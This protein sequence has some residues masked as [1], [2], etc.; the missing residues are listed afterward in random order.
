M[1][2]SAI[3]VGMAA[4][5]MGPGL[6][7][8]S[9]EKPLPGTPATFT[10]LSTELQGETNHVIAVSRTVW[11]KSGASYSKY[12]IDCLGPSFRYLA[13]GS[14]PESIETL[15]PD[16]RMRALVNGS[17]SYWITMEACKQVGDQDRAL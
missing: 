16:P 5:F 1:L 14:T 12:E 6:V 10:I 11:P 15:R 13:T 8:A 7:G 2:R 17:A 4:M 3:A 9:G